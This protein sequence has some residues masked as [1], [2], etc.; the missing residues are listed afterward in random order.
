MSRLHSAITQTAGSVQEES[1]QVSI[2]PML[3]R[4]VISAENMHMVS[5]QEACSFDE[6]KNGVVVN[7]GGL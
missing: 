5:I 1:F 2:Q 6:E 7:G 4:A 3:K